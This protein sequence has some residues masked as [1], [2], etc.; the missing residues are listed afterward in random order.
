MDD[1]RQI[2]SEPVVDQMA[3]K[4]LYHLQKAAEIEQEIAR[5]QYST[6]VNIAYLGPWHN[7]LRMKF[8]WYYR[9]HMSRIAHFLHY[10]TLI[11]YLGLWLWIFMHK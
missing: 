2:K 10:A 11:V 6:K 3:E 4:E 1:E 7:A 5:I 9:W 8:N